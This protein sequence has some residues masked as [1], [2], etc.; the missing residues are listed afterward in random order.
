M[1][2]LRGPSSQ[3]PS[4]FFRSLVHAARTL[5]A[6]G[7]SRVTLSLRQ[8]HLRAA[9]GLRQEE[10]G[11]ETCPKT[12][13]LA[14]LCAI[15]DASVHAAAHDSPESTSTASSY[16]STSTYATVRRLACLSTSGRG[17]RDKPP[18]GRKSS[19]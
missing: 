13:L 7:Q 14:G 15:A 5:N 18:R 3:D 6:T 11:P 19:R 10:S 9:R 12:M 4:F 17:L 8:E 16:V 1:Q 2:Y